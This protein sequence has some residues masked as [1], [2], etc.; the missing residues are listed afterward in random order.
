MAARLLDAVSPMQALEKVKV[1]YFIPKNPKA[2]DTG[3]LGMLRCEPISH[4]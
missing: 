4:D 2:T 3:L 1:D